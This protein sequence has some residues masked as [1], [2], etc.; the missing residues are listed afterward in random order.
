M[1]VCPLPSAIRGRS[2]E[3]A[4]VVPVPPLGSFWFDNAGASALLVLLSVPPLL[5]LGGPTPIPSGQLLFS[6][7]TQSGLTILLKR[8]L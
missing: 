1:P 7:G 8:R 3:G 4:G 2:V 5:R 6:D